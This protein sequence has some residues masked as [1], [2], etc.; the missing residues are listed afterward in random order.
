MDKLVTHA[1][2][3]TVEAAEQV[4]SESRENTTSVQPT[5]CRAASVVHP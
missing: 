1:S 3:R 2:D 4:R 5:H